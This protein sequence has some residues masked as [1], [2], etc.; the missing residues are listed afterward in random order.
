MPKHVWSA[1][2][3]NRFLPTAPQCSFK[4]KSE[5]PQ[6]IEKQQEQHKTKSQRNK[7]YKIKHSEAISSECAK[8]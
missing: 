4:F 3:V 5:T 7:K 6:A 2:P 8:K 1:E